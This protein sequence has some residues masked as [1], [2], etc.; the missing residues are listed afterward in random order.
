[1]TQEADKDGA[2]DQGHT[3]GYC[4]VWTQTGVPDFKPVV[5]A[6]VPGG[7]GR[8][9]HEAGRSEAPGAL[10]LSHEAALQRRAARRTQGSRP[11]QPRPSQP[12]PLAAPP[13]GSLAAPAPECAGPSGGSAPVRG[14][15]PRGA[16]PSG[17]SCA[18]RSAA[19]GAAPSPLRPSPLR[20]S[21]RGPAASGARARPP[22][23]TLFR[24]VVP[25]D[26]ARLGL[27]ALRPGPEVTRSPRAAGCEARRGGC[28]PWE[29]VRGRGGAA[30]GGG[31][32]GAAGGSGARSA[33]GLGG[34]RAGGWGAGGSPRLRRVRWRRMLFAP[35]VSGCG[36]RS[37]RGT[38]ALGWPGWSP[39]S[40]RRCG[41]RRCWEGNSL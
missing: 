27:S 3:P 8:G 7:E 31:A 6:C 38:P 25:A 17:A 26:S 20:P 11:S 28:H 39:C 19:S 41:G 36:C 2:A 22:S 4:R 14:L 37:R 16:P 32:V 30:G 21:P 23:R 9:P 1:M 13:P 10:G 35:G 12:R 29:G 5:S 15:R 18:G 33:A 40:G 34:G 24:A